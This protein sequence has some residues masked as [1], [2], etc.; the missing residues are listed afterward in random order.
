MAKRKRFGFPE[1]EHR[2][3]ARATARETRESLVPML[4]RNLS[5]G[6]CHRAFARLKLLLRSEGSF[7][8][9]RAAVTGANFPRKGSLAKQV[10]RL[11][12]EFGSKCVIK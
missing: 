3:R 4:K 2:R 8:E 6:Q 12:D 9:N 1:A 10:Q 5:E 7:Y 11:A